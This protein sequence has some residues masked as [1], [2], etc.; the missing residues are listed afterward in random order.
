MT[1]QI[2]KDE[3]GDHR[4]GRDGFPDDEAYEEATTERHLDDDRGRHPGSSVSFH[5]GKGKH[6]L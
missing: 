5:I 1:Y 3:S 6:S 2:G 4:M